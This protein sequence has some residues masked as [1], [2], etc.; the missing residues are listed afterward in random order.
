[1]IASTR[2]WGVVSGRLY[3]RN[4]GDLAQLHEGLG[5]FVRCFSRMF[6]G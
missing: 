5:V 1:M 4:K 3:F 6:S 2:V